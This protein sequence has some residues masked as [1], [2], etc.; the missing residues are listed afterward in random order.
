[1]APTVQ[2]LSALAAAVELQVC[3]DRLL[4][5][6]FPEI[7]ED[8]PVPPDRA[9]RHRVLE[10]VIEGDA[11]LRA[12]LLARDDTRIGER[13]RQCLHARTSD[14]DLHH[15]LAVLYRER[16]LR[17]NARTGSAGER[18]AVATTLWAL[19]L[20]DEA[21]WRRAGVARDD[22]DAPREKI[23]GG[24]LDLH[25][26]HGARALAAD[27]AVSARLHL[28][29]LDACRSGDPEA[30]RELLEEFGV[31]ND[32]RVDPRR[33]T[34]TARLAA[35]AVD[36]W[37]DDLVEDA[38]S[39]V[40]DP[41]AV[42]ALPDGIDQDYEAGIGRLAPFIRLGVAVRRVLVTGME[43]HNDWAMCH[44]NNR[45]FDQMKDVL[46]SG[47]EFC[48]RLV[49][50]C[51]PGEA[52]RPENQAVSR[53]LLLRGVVTDTDE[54]AI[55]EMKEA[56]RWNPANDNATRVLFQ[57]YLG[58]GTRIAND[59]HAV[60]GL[61]GPLPPDQRFE[62]AADELR[63]A[64]ELAERPDDVQ[65][66]RE[67]LASVLTLWAINLRDVTTGSAART[68]ARGERA[69]RLVVEALELDPENELARR[70]LDQYDR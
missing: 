20:A 13:W 24:L 60:R 47:R 67:R 51:A 4:A 23:I 3:T 8:E 53:Y 70:Y 17:Q 54:K 64:L 12:A 44:Y 62:K 45:A 14:L 21:F 18:L 31:R 29:C 66:V 68:L 16:A 46:A 36:R 9:G 25:A 39:R 22:E 61:A 5:H 28:R 26:A 65:L 41:V 15:D 10:T 35:A 6:I 40:A 57:S 52:H 50:L 2:S 59:E 11:E 1:M 49:R 55:A 7:G 30:V 56:L 34:G 48:D 33:L 32:R 38:Q 58:R 63:R 37:C 43:W 42:G 19:L 69:R 27:R